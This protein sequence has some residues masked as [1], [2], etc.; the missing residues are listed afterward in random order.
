[1]H[2][3]LLAGQMF[4]CHNHALKKG[5]DNPKMTLYNN[6]IMGRYGQSILFAF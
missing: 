6:G 1:M 4:F 2:K 5:I 3:S